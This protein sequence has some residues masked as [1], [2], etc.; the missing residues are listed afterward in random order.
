[1]NTRL[2][3][4]GMLA[5]LLSCLVLCGCGST[6]EYWQPEQ[7]VTEQPLQAS[8]AEGAVTAGWLEVR[9]TQQV[10]RRESPVERLTLLHEKLESTVDWDGV[11]MTVVYILG[12]LLVLGIYLFFAADAWT[13]KDD[14]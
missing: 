5:A 2:R 11:A 14:E 10:L 12:S 3:K 8:R 13:R 9:L 6:S 4:A 7:Q 1:M